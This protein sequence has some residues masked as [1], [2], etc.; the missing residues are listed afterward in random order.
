[1]LC[2]LTWIGLWV[3]LLIK[4]WKTGPLVGMSSW[5]MLWIF[6]PFF[7]KLI[8]AMLF[9]EPL[10][11]IADNKPPEKTLP[12]TWNLIKDTWRS[13]IENFNKT[14]KTSWLFIIVSIIQGTILAPAYYFG[15]IP[16]IIAS[17]AVVIPLVM[18]NIYLTLMVFSHVKSLE[19]NNPYQPPQPKDTIRQAL[20]FLWIGLLIVVIAALPLMLAIGL[21]FGGIALQTYSLGGNALQITLIV[22]GAVL[23]IPATIWSIYKSTI[24]NSFALPVFVIEG[25]KG[26]Q[27]LKTNESLAK[28]RWWG[29]F[30][31]NQ[32]AGL[33]FGAFGMLIS[34]ALSILVL[35]L[36][37]LFRLL[38]LSNVINIFLTTALNGATQ[39]ILVPLMMTYSLK[40]YKTFK[41]TSDNLQE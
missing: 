39:I 3:W 11:R 21:I 22:A 25:K 40:I 36:T 29:L 31:K 1:M 26:L 15:E 41:L 19:E 12:L 14:F 35:V 30:W 23:A 18:G 32:M 10:K 13:Y 34:L 5:D 20:S 27:N 9:L 8:I 33:T 38:N 37:V 16:Y 2:F 28:K 4:L 24:Y 7:G 6:F 17:V